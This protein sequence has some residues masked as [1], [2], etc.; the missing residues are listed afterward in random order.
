MLNLLTAGN[1]APKVN[2]FPKIDQIDYHREYPF[3]N[4]NLLINHPMNRPIFEGDIHVKQILKLMMSDGWIECLQPIYVGSETHFIYNGGHTN[5]AR[6]K[7]IESTGMSPVF[8]V[9]FVDDSNLSDEEKKKLIQALNWGKPWHCDDYC[10][11][12][13]ADGNEDFIC[14]KE[15]CLDEDRPYLH[16]DKGKPH[17]SKG[18]VAFGTTNTEFKK[19]YQTGKWRLT[20]QMIQSAPER[21]YRLTRIRKALGLDKAGHDFWLNIGEGWI[22]FEREGYIPRLNALPNRFET[23]CETLALSGT[24]NSYKKDDWLNKFVETLKRAEKENK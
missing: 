24:M 19:A 17:F 2:I 15:F 18:A 14:L 5:E 9:K 20:H 21:Y 8:Y 1:P 11:A 3:D 7:F 22:N 12:L 6:K 23:F 13:I 4:P 16:T 10:N